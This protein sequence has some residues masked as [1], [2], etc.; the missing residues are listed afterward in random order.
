[1]PLYLWYLVQFCCCSP[2]NNESRKVV[3][4][5]AEIKRKTPFRVLPSSWKLPLWKV[6]QWQKGWATSEV[7]LICWYGHGVVSYLT[8][9]TRNT[10]FL[11]QI[12]SFWKQLLDWQG[13]LKHWD[14]YSQMRGITQNTSLWF[15]TVQNYFQDTELRTK[16]FWIIFKWY[17]YIKMIFESHKINMNYEDNI[18]LNLILEKEVC[19]WVHGDFCRSIVPWAIYS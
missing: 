8:S 1:M 2:I 5:K 13:G 10:A 9:L 16:L 4:H 14:T 12:K 15:S 19:T 6:I 7:T 3:V 18:A 11:L 17:L